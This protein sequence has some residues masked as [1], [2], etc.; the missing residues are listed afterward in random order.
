MRTKARRAEHRNRRTRERQ[1]LVRH[2]VYVLNLLFGIVTN[3]CE[4]TAFG[5][6]WLA[7]SNLTAPDVRIEHEVDGMQRRAHVSPPLECPAPLP[8]PSQR[9]LHLNIG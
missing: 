5:S 6:H 4:L 8:E 3:G 7:P 2:I 9:S 1:K